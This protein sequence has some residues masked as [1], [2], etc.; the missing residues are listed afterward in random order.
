[1]QDPNADTEWNAVLRQKGILPPKEIT[2][3]QLADMIEETIQKKQNGKDLDEMNLDELDELE[4]EED[5]RILD[6]YRKRRLEELAAYSQKAKFGDV[7]QISKPDYLNEVNK[8]GQGIWV[9]LHLFKDSLPQCK[10]LNM[11]LQ[12]LARKFPTTKFLKIVGTDCIPNYPDKNMPTIFVYYEG[13]MKQQIVGL[14]SLGG[15]KTTA[16]DVE[17][18]LKRIG[19]VPSEMEENPRAKDAIRDVMSNFVGRSGYDD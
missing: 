19:A 9:V 17:W 11:H 10:L 3:D 6:M 12:T 2:E 7:V 1:M 4:D 14:T 16:A 13:D 8:A 15:D 5:E 18:A